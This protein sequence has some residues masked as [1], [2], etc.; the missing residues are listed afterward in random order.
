MKKNFTINHCPQEEYEMNFT[1]DMDTWQ[2][3]EVMDGNTTNKDD[4]YL[5]TNTDKHNGNENGTGEG[6]LEG[7][8]IDASAGKLP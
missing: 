7:L 3:A 1:V 5:L 6:E 4:P 2:N 8:V